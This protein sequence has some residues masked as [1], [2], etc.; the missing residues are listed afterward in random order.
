[1]DHSTVSHDSRQ[2]WPTS[3]R[4]LV[5]A[6]RL[7]QLGRVVFLSLGPFAATWGMLGGTLA[8]QAGTLDRPIPNH[9][10]PQGPA[11]PIS[12]HNASVMSDEPKPEEQTFEEFL[13]LHPGLS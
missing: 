3:A 4:V 6:Q 11:A 12:Q 13:K 5:P 9:P 2:L 1:M 7:W 8:L 10:R